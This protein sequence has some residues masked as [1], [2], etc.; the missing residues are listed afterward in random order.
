MKQN[1]VKKTNLSDQELQNIA[2]GNENISSHYANCHKYKT[3]DECRIRV[4]TW[5]SKQEAC[6]F[7]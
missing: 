1:D 2:S 3:E 4:C 6:L 5:N 7:H